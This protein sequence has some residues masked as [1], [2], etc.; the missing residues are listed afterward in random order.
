[1]MRMY[2]SF[3]VLMAALLLTFVAVSMAWQMFSPVE[4]DA[5]DYDTGGMHDN[6]SL[7][8]RITIPYIAGVSTG[9]WIISASG[10]TDVTTGRSDCQFRVNG[11]TSIGFGGGHAS[12]TIGPYEL[13]TQYVFSAGDYV[14][15]LV[16][17][18]AGAGNVVFDLGF[19][20]FFMAAFLGRVT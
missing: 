8:T 6:I 14:E 15:C 7:S 20:P 13:T 16:R 3:L 9:V 4:F 18:T 19:S 5:E 10:Y 12:T 11:V 1:M 17:T 2:L